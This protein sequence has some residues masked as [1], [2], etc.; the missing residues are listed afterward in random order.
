MS[1]SLTLLIVLM[2]CQGDAAPDGNKNP[3]TDCTGTDCDTDTPPVSDADGDGFDDI[4][5]GGQDCDDTDDTIHPDATEVCDG[6]DNDCNDLVDEDDPDLDTTTLTDWYRDL[7]G[8]GFGDVN[9]NA[10]KACASP[11][12]AVED[13]TDCN[14][15]D[16]D[17]NP[18]GIEV[19]GDCIDNDCDG[20]IG[21]TECAGMLYMVRESDGMVRRLDTLT[22]VFADVGTLGVNFDY[23]ELAWDVNLGVMYMIDGQG[24]DSLYTVDIGTGSASLVGAHGQRD[25]FGLAVAPNGTLY[26]TNGV[27]GGLY[28]LNAA[29]GA[30]TFIGM[31]RPKAGLTWDTTRS[32]L[33]GIANSGDIAQLD[34]VNAQDTWLANPGAIEDCGLAYDEDTDLFWVAD[35][36]G[37]LYTYDPNNGYART[38]VQ[39]NLG[40]HDGLTFGP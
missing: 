35:Q 28:S 21:D 11:S 13:N 1:R 33:V 12:G 39:S 10:Q 15:D 19:P 3:A 18:D 38:L 37:D 4:A 30:A 6:A 32:T 14:D 2:A 9:G 5:L 34:P 24:G 22:M 17:V 26:A 20:V 31:S 27:D 8:D 23:G 25:M 36:G 16:A 29:N 7:D 40:A